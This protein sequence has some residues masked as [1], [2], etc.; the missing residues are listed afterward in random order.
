MTA[1]SKTLTCSA[2]IVPGG[3]F[4]AKNQ[5]FF[6]FFFKIK[7]ARTRARWIAIAKSGAVTNGRQYPFQTF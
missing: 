3:F 7:R 5:N 1:C 4:W 6:F 2:V